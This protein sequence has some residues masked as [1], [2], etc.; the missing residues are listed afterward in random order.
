M[1]DGSLEPLRQQDRHPVSGLDPLALKPARKGGGLL[2][3]GAVSQRAMIAIRAEMLKADALRRSC[4]PCIADSHADI[5]PL[6][7]LPLEG[8]VEFVVVLDCR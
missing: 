5:E 7:D 4:R 6:G 8:A 2:G 3:K 1:R